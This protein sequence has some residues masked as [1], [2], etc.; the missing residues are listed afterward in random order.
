M[1]NDIQYE[2]PWKATLS[3]AQELSSPNQF[4]LVGSVAEQGHTNLMAVSWWT[5]LSNSPPMVAVSLSS[6]SYTNACV[7]Q[8]R[9]FTLSTVDCSIARQAMQCGKMTGKTTDKAKVLGIELH[10]SD[11]VCPSY[12][13]K[14]RIA[15]ECRVV[16][17]VGAGDHT[18][19]IAEVLGIHT[20]SSIRALYAINGYRDLAPVM[21]VQAE[22]TE[23]Y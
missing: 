17:T 2:L 19:F 12:V 7:S 16:Q 4:A 20:D 13:K 21:Q 5:Y 11:V 8:S 1:S 23:L 14:S 18:V 3:Q 6:R 15:L 10:V 22:T 9:E